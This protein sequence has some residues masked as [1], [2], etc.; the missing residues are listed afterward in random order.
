MF[1]K[2][3]PCGGGPPIPLD[4]DT[5]V[6][7]RNSGCDIVITC[8]SVSGRHCELQFRDGS[9]WVRDLESTHGTA[10]NGVKRT[11]ERVEPN[12]V[13]SVGRRR[14][15]L[16]YSSKPAL[17]LA[18]DHD[19]EALAF[20]FLTADDEP[21]APPASKPGSSAVASRQPSK[22]HE[23]RRASLGKLVPCGGGD[24]IPLPLPDVTI[25][26]D[27]AC[28]ICLPFRTISARHC[29]LNLSAGYW[30]VEDL[31][32]SNGT[33]VNGTRCQQDRLLPNSV[34]GVATHRFTMHYT[35]T[36]ARRA[37]DQ[38]VWF[39]QSLLEKADAIQSLLSD[40]L[41]GAQQSERDA[42]QRRRYRP[43]L[44]E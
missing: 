23:P 19:V 34:L 18:A 20:S 39:T 9:W 31:K 11:H 40:R 29:R 4:Q 25:G 28:E 1:G 33:W 14:F 12:N 32:S 35:L 13:L 5:I 21:T 24:P 17:S 37:P 10:V 8:P 27:P 3:V 2:L 30:F 15:I 38:E 16:T 22:S 7:G 42:D 26:R 36:G 44:D 41:P 6:I 43:D